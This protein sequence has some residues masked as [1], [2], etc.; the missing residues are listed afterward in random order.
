MNCNHPKYI[1]INGNM[2]CSQC[3]VLIS[4]NYGECKN[5]E[6]LYKINPLMAQLIVNNKLNNQT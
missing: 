2:H 1:Y 6:L 5:I 3:R 4:D